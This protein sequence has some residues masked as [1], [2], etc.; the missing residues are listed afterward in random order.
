M[1]EKRL[2]ALARR[3]A[4]GR[5]SRRCTHDPEI[6]PCDAAVLATEL[7]RQ[8]AWTDFASDLLDAHIW[9]F[10]A[11]DWQ[12]SEALAHALE[13]ADWPP[14][15]ARDADDPAH[16]VV[17]E[18]VWPTGS[19]GT[20]ETKLDDLSTRPRAQ[21]RFRTMLMSKGPERSAS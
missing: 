12:A 15:W 3:H 4:A 14:H 20:P 19:E 10:S 16:I 6:A 2:Q 21:I 13:G 9:G 1:N 5:P 17:D 18:S 7:A 11:G 8:R